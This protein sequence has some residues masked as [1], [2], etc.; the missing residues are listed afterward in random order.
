MHSGIIPSYKTAL[1]PM[2]GVIL[3]LAAILVFFWL[4]PAIQGVKG[5]AGYPPLHTILELFAVIVCLQVFSVGWFAH[6]SVQYKNLVLLAT[7]FLGVG[8]LDVMHALS[9]R[10][11]PDFITSNGTEK[12][13]F[14]WTAARFFSALGLLAISILP[15]RPLSGQIKR[16]RSLAAML[17]VVLLVIW[18]GLY[19]LDWFPHTF[20]HGQGL[21]TIKVSLEY[22]LVAMFLLAALRLFMLMREKQPFDVVGLFTASIIMAFSELFFTLYSDTADIFMILGHVYKVIAYIFIYKSLF[23]YNVSYPYRRLQEANIL[24]EQQIADRIRAEDRQRISEL[25]FRQLIELSPL[26]ISVRDANGKLKFINRRF[27]EIFGYEFEDIE[28]RAQWR[29]KAFPDAA[30]RAEVDIGWKRLQAAAVV[31][32]GLMGSKEYEITC[33]DG[34]ER[35]VQTTG[36][37]LGGI[38]FVIFNDQTEQRAAEIQTRTLWTAIEQSPL[39]IVICNLE[40]NITYVNPHFVS[41]TGYSPQEVL[42]KNMNILKSGST[43]TSTYTELWQKITRGENWQGELCNRKKNGEYYWE[44]V[45]IAPVRGGD[46]QVNNF[47]GIQLDITQ[48]KLIEDELRKSNEMLESR[49]LERTHEL[50]LAKKDAE[51]ASE[52]K[53]SFLANMSHEIRTP[54]NSIIGMTHLVLRGQLA[55]KEREYITNIHHVS[56]HLLNVINDIL[57]FSKIEAG[58]MTLESIDFRMQVVLDHIERQVSDALMQKNLKLTCEV[59]PDLEGVLRGDP[60]RLGQVLLNYIS[61]A[62]KFTERGEI[63]V[64]ARLIKADEKGLLVRFSVKDTGIGISPAQIKQLFQVFHQADASTT[65]KFGGTGLGLAICKKIAEM[66]GGT[67]GVESQPGQGSEFWFELY[68]IRGEGEGAYPDNLQEAEHY[69][70]KGKRILLVEDNLFNQKVGMELLD[71]VGADVIIANNGREATRIIESES[72][73]CVLMDVQMPVMDGF[74]ATR[75]MRGNPALATL[76]IIAMT[77]NVGVEDQQRCLQAGMTDF[78]AKPIQP[79]VMYATIAKQ[80]GIIR[81]AMAENAVS[82]SALPKDVSGL[83]AIDLS[84]LEDTWGNNRL[85]VIQYAKIFAETLEENLGQIDLAMASNDIPRMTLLAHSCKSAAR[86]VGAREMGDLCEQLENCKSLDKLQEARSLMERMRPIMLNILVETSRL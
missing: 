10:G 35:V 56:Q 43:A 85:K 66:M 69:N 24:L 33:K 1:K 46:D 18:S 57:D 54:L 62:I 72:F 82:A 14:F 23:L 36:S 21:T 6:G 4:A 71:I 29:L 78:I 40:G 55:Q 38:E 19:H 27:I 22:V 60:L 70:L 52:A 15:W 5:I 42:G 67:L 51:A 65:R 81:I 74:E 73:D 39:S 76:P 48:R 20:I 30:Y 84:V 41:L 49:V 17:A 58:K 53:S 86:T 64:L 80:L 45:H 37:V 28:S 16:W 63:V 59:D 2:M 75:I 34:K 44:N 7:T 8:L 26:P 3:F 25:N 13:I 50:Q 12:A 31:N 79:K 83:S 32:N 9:I 11:M 47:V 61:N 68:L 77:A